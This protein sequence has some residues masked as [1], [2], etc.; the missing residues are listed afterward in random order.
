MLQQTYVMA[1]LKGTG[2]CPFPGANTPAEAG[3]TAT[4]PSHFPYDDDVQR[5][6]CAATRKVGAALGSSGIADRAFI[7]AILMPG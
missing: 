4:H 2:T 5:T 6:S 7:R 1:Y 3:K